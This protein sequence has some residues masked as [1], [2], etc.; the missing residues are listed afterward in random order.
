MTLH[1]FHF[2][3]SPIKKCVFVLNG[4]I[5]E[6]T[7]IL[8]SVRCVR[9]NWKVKFCFTHV[10]LTL[11]SVDEML[12]CD[13]S[14]VIEHKCSRWSKTVP[15]IFCTVFGYRYRGILNTLL[16]GRSS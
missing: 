6:K 4:L 8:R 1:L 2:K 3:S 10:V 14:D 9:I 5:L 12:V 15:E 13:S 11:Q 16:H 7:G